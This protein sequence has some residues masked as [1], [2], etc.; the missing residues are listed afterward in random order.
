MI[1]R[2]SLVILATLLLSS[3][4]LKEKLNTP[5]AEQFTEKFE[6]FVDFFKPD[7]LNNQEFIIFTLLIFIVLGACAALINSTRGFSFFNEPPF[8][9]RFLSVLLLSPAFLM[10]PFRSIKHPGWAL[11]TWVFLR[12]LYICFLLLFTFV[13]LFYLAVI[14]PYIIGIAI[15]IIVLAIFAG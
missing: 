5:D 7:E 12:C 15:I 13:I 2:G 9:N 1:R 10:F 6:W 4:G 8:Q 11:G 3:C 14:L